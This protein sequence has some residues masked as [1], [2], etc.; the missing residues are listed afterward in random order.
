MSS[1]ELNLSDESLN[2]LA[3]LVLARATELGLLVPVKEWLTMKEA[4]QVS[5]LSEHEIRKR[6]DRGAVK[7]HQPNPG[8]PPLLINRLSLLASMNVES[9]DSKKGGS[10]SL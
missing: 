5:N 9:Q 7:T 6:I 1:I 3:H 2:A 4:R 10:E 8:R